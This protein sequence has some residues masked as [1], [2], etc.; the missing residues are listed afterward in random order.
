MSELETIINGK[1]LFKPSYTMNKER[2]DECSFIYFIFSSRVDCFSKVSFNVW[3]YL[4]R[5]QKNVF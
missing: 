1:V 2:K 5:S 4:L 3:S